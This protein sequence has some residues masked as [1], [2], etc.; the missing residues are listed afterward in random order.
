MTHLLNAKPGDL[1]IDEYAGYATMIF[2]IGWA[3][4]GLFFGVLGDRIG[5]AKTM[6][7][8]ILMYSA[9]TG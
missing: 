9:F 8:T 1:K 4:G 6:L 7:L 3:I 5:R 2:M